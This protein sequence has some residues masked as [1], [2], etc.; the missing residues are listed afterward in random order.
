[1]SDVESEVA[2]SACD[3]SSWPATLMVTYVGCLCMCAGISKRR[4]SSAAT[5]GSHPFT[6]TQA[7]PSPSRPA[8]VTVTA[9]SSASIRIV[10]MCRIAQSASVSPFGPWSKLDSGKWR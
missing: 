5:Y 2:L 1:M 8:D 9:P 3:P 7:V 6:I 4:D 10:V